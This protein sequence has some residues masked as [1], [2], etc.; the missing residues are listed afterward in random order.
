[1]DRLLI[2]ARAR[3]QDAADLLCFLKARRSVGVAII[4][5]VLLGLSFA[6]YIIESVAVAPYVYPLF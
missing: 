6:L 3:W 2:R 4:V 5:F 1:M